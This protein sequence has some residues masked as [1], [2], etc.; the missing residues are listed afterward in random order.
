MHRTLL[1]MHKIELVHVVR[2]MDNRSL[3]PGVDKANTFKSITKRYIP[4][5]NMNAEEG[6][7]TLMAIIYRLSIRFSMWSR[8]FERNYVH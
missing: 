2:L 6:D 3:E 7:V 8:H 4:S 1:Y 5:D